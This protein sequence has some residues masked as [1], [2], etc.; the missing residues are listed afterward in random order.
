MTM[1]MTKETSVMILEMIKKIPNIGNTIVNFS[2]E[3]HY[4][5]AMH[6]NPGDNS[7]EIAETAIA[8]IKVA[9]HSRGEHEKAELIEGKHLQ[10][11]DC[12]KV[13]ENYT[14]VWFKI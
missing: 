13:G 8:A 6:H 5:V 14:I 9:H 4:V 12:L 1:N 10:M 2:G 7:V 3:G 11:G